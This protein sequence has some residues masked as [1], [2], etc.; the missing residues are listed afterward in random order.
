MSAPI[1]IRIR[2]RIAF[3]QHDGR[4]RFQIP[5]PGIVT[6]VCDE[7]TGVVLEMWLDAYPH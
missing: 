2:I 1:R 6:T 7:D 5:W 4:L 3:T